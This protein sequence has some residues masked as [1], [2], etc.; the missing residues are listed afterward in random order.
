MI[1]KKMS[2]LKMLE[3]LAWGRIG[4]MEFFDVGNLYKNVL[5]S[6]VNL[7]SFIDGEK[8]KLTHTFLNSE[9]SFVE[10][11]KTFMEAYKESETKH[12]RL[13]CLHGENPIIVYTETGMESVMLQQ[14]LNISFQDLIEDK[15]WA[16]FADVERFP[17]KIVDQTELITGFPFVTALEKLLLSDSHYMVQ[18]HTGKKIYV[19]EE[20]IKD[21]ETE[22]LV[23]VDAGLHKGGHWY[24]GD[25]IGNDG[26]MIVSDALT[27]ID[28]NNQVLIFG[29]GTEDEFVIETKAIYEDIDLRDVLPE[30]AQ[31]V[32]VKQ[33]FTQPLWTVKNKTL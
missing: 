1:I 23:V 2:A 16:G 25:K 7:G 22:Q 28:W 8:I 21:A 10:K 20:G 29:E 26:A 6:Q 19:D 15:Y 12:E 3:H 17:V 11:H 4:D 31:D 24:V 14:F 18:Y 5:L 27:Y 30:H 13:A 32:N 33:L 9:W